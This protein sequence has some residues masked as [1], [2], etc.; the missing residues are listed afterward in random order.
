MVRLLSAGITCL[1]SIIFLVP[2]VI[3]L[4]YFVLRQRSFCKWFM[5]LLLAVYLTMVFSVTGLPTAYTLQF[6]LSVNLVPLADI[7]NSPLEYVKNTLL[8]IVLFMPL[9]F[10][11]PVIWREYRSAKTMAIVG[12]AVSLVI[13]LLQLF[14]FR[15]TDVDDLIMNTLGAVIGYAAA[16]KLSFQMP[17]QMPENNRTV[18]AKYEPVIVWGMVFVIGFF[19]KPLVENTVWEAVLSGTW[20]ERIR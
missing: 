19:L 8:N 13:E 12:L 18:L 1:S 7:V 16:K 9:G 2:A 3:V 5:V 14:T 15:H 6:D 11:L 17:F 10:L 4:Q 20:W